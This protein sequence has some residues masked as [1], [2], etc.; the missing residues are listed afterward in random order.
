MMQRR[1]VCQL[2]LCVCILAA[3]AA[4]ADPPAQSNPWEP[5]ESSDPTIVLAAR[6]VP[7]QRF[8]EV[9][10]TVTLNAPIATVASLIDDDTRVRSLLPY[11]L[12]ASVDRTKGDKPLLYAWFKG[13]WPFQKREVY[14]WVSPRCDAA[15]HSI[16]VDFQTDNLPSDLPAPKPSTVRM[17][18]LR[19][20]WK[21]TPGTVPN[22]T[23]VTYQAYADIGTH[24]W[25]GWI[26]NHATPRLVRQVLY[27]LRKHATGY[28]ETDLPRLNQHAPQLFPAC[29]K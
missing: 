5:I 27:L 12:E 19:G 23:D 26:N 21:L 11:A 4:L 2:A 20:F 13:R 7:G 3:T 22:T 6:D 15:S 16:L 18:T 25:L 10:G 17:P 1:I 14:F 8:R 29:L 24:G 28:T 9:R